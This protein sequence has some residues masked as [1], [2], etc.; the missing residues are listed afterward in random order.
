MGVSESCDSWETASFE[1]LKALPIK[2]RRKREELMNIRLKTLHSLLYIVEL[3]RLPRFYSVSTEINE[4]EVY[5]QLQSPLPHLEKR[6]FKGFY[7]SANDSN[8]QYFTESTKSICDASIDMFIGLCNNGIE[9]RIYFALEDDIKPFIE[10][11]F[12]NKVVEHQ[13]RYNGNVIGIDKCGKLTDQTLAF[14]KKPRY[15]RV[16]TEILENIKKILQDRADDYLQIEKCLISDSIAG[17]LKQIGDDE[18]LFAKVD[19]ERFFKIPDT[20]SKLK[21]HPFYTSEQLCKSNEIIYPKGRPCGE[22]KGNR[23]YHKKY[24][25]KIR[26]EKGWFREGRVLKDIEGN[27]G[28]RNNNGGIRAKPYRIVSGKYCY[29]F[30]QTRAVSFNKITGV[31]MDAF[32]PNFIPKNS[33]YIEHNPDV[34]R[35][36]N[37]KYSNCV[38]GFRRGEPI[39]S[40]FF[41]EKKYCNLIN[42]V[43]IEIK[44]YEEVRNFNRDYESVIGE[45]KLVLKKAGLYLKIKTHIGM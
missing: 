35:L 34:C 16:F 28:N 22:L 14:S 24:I 15:H 37:I 3:L 1:E 44:Y 10:Y 2:E 4:Y 7:R 36:L 20:L 19:Y 9:S 42:E 26:T 43:L 39:T 27:D 21:I 5:K 13:G 8:T 38:V 29:A 6:L 25:Q 30:F 41:I 17:V 33:V 18:G 11:T 23:I 31:A 45:W 32:H 40:G 12:R